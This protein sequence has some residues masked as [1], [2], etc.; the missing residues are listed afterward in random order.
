MEFQNAEWLDM[1]N[2]RNKPVFD[3]IVAETA[4]LFM[5][6]KLDEQT[7]IQMF[8]HTIYQIHLAIDSGEFKGEILAPDNRIVKFVGL[9]IAQD[10]ETPSQ[11]IMTPVWAF[12]DEEE[13]EDEWV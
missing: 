6:Q 8:N 1:A 3:K 4:R 2:T 9:R 13:E 12:D 10:K 11:V 7:M 5:N